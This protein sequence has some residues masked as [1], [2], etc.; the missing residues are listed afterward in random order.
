[1]NFICR[2]LRGRISID[3]NQDSPDSFIVRNL[4]K[5]QNLKISEKVLDILVGL[6][7]NR[8]VRV[9]KIKSRVKEERNE[10]KKEVFGHFV[11]V[12]SYAISR[13]DNWVV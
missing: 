7:Y 1:M 2:E 3:T 13:R 8:G 12:G 10:Y 11:P 6:A 5:A 9:I 4:R